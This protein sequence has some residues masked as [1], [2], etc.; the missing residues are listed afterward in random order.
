MIVGLWMNFTNN[1]LRFLN[2]N[3]MIHLR[4]IFYTIQ[5]NNQGSHTGFQIQVK[6]QS[7]QIVNM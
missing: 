2:R 3:N 7:L 5:N 1:V 4:F 6:R